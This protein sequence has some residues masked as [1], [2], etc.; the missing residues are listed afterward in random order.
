MLQKLTLRASSLGVSARVLAG[1]GIIRPYSP[2]VLAALLRTVMTWGTGPAGGF[3]T[4]ALRMPDRVGLVDE[5]G[6][7]TFG[8]LH[9][10]SNALAR[11]LQAQGVGEGDSVAVMCRNHRYFV[12]VSIAVAKLGADLLYL[13]TSFAG[14]QL[15]DVLERE[16]PTVVVHDEEFTEMLAAAATERRVVAWADSD[17]E[18]DVPTVEALIGSESTDDLDA[19]QRH[20]RIVILTSGTTGTP[21]GAPRNE[22][23]IDAAVS[24]LSRMPLRA[25]WRTHIAAPLFHTWGFAHLALA[26]L[27]G[28]TVVL[29]RKFDPEGALE[30]AESERCDSI[31]VIPVMLQRILALPEDTLASY[32]LSRVKVVA[33]S[34]SALPGD[35][36]LSWMDHFGDNL[37]N[38][39]G[40][41]E[42]AYASIATPQ[43]LRE[44]PSSAGRPPYAT[45]VRILDSEGHELPAGESG[46]IFVGNNLL[47]EGYTGGGHKDMVDGLMSSGDVGRI[48]EDGRLYVEG[49]DDEMIVSGGEN[50]FPKEVEDCLMRHE[51]VTDAAAVGVDDDDYGK[52]LKA[53]VVVDADVGED[54]L[55]DWVK[56]NLAR[57][58]VPREI[59]VLDELPRNSTGKVL[60][61]ELA[62]DERDS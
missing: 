50:V 19:P 40:S 39:Y 13:N 52:R 24:L 29:R 7:L 42:V 47:F 10:R 48:G 27:L 1:S 61:R 41:T 45:V 25:G 6:E 60:K 22:A 54:D 43:D 17:D 56:Q 59:V 38:I 23:G 20:C 34:G 21:K 5:L 16:Q 57:Y 26:M 49:R 12:D 51:H 32:D 35:L 4:L 37:Y 15:V 11:A 53:F 3:A 2:R 36:A 33:A 28:S 14:P 58:K 18:P 44:A 55:K 31:V 9:T 8:E 46:R 30:A 62:K